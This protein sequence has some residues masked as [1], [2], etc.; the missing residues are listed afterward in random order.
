LE[1]KKQAVSA[2]PDLTVTQR[3]A[4][5]QFIMLACDGIWDCLSNEECCESLQ[6]K[7]TSIKPKKD[8][9]HKVVDKLLDEILA[10]NTE[11]GIGTDN[12]TAILVKFS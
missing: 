10:P 11:D 3:K 6:K 4:G 8:E 1:A 12:M 9:L 2:F 7:L 5:D